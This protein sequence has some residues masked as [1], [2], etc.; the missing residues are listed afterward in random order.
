VFPLDDGDVLTIHPDLEATAKEF[1]RFSAADAD[2]LRA[3]ITDWNDGL[4]VAHAH[5]SAGLPLPVSPWTT[6]YE[7]LRRRSAWDVIMTTFE[8]PVPRQVVAWMAFATLQPPERIGTGALPAA[9]MAGR[10]S[11]GWTTAIGGSGALPDALVAH[12]R[13][14][15]GTVETSAWVDSY[16]VEDGRCVG[17]RTIDG[18][19][20][21]ASRAVV[22]G[23]HLKT[24]PDMLDVESPMATD[25]AARW[26]P[27]IPV[28][29]VH[30]ALKSDITYRTPEGPMTAVAGALGSPEGMRRQVDGAYA[31]RLETVDPWLLMVSSTAVDADRAPG[32]VFKFLSIAPMLLDGL[33]WTEEDATSYAEALLTFARKHVDGLEP[34]N[35][36]AMLPESPTTLAAHNL[37]NIGGSCHGGEFLMDDGEVIPGWLDYRTDL[38]GL[39]LTGSTSHPGGSVSGRPGRNAA[40]AVLEDLGIDP[41]TVMSTP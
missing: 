15:G 12:L 25:A 30:F 22:A 26:R 2:A 38:P 24:L 8:H 16:L 17:A 5:Y 40:R 35:I 10:I 3:M 21:R 33:P 36:L 13:D 14:H 6:Q 34:D 19:V 41:A 9:I 20:F 7:A 28:F 23:S 18:R 32:G 11:F 39:F 29:A 1:A 37:A 27:G 31:G 4:R